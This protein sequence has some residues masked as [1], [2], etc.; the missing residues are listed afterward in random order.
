MSSLSNAAQQAYLG[1][2]IKLR[3]SHLLCGFSTFHF[4]FLLLSTLRRDF[5]DCMQVNTC[6]WKHR[7]TARQTSTFEVIV[8]VGLFWASET[9][10]GLRSLPQSG[11]CGL[12]V[13]FSSSSES[14][15]CLAL[16]L[17]WEMGQVGM[18]SI[19]CSYCPRTLNKGLL[20]LQSFCF[21]LL[22]YLNIC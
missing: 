3:L 12:Q 1:L 6:R 10:V 15:V 2:I 4:R 5:H 22:C 18:G 17:V 16:F 11:I 20:M 8:A 9:V 14:A 21:F 19:E 13:F 7:W